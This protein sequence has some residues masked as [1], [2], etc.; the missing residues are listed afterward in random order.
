M[1]KWESDESAF[2][3]LEGKLGPGL[4]ALFH[5]IG[6]MPVDLSRGSHGGLGFM[7]HGVYPP[8]AVE[9]PRFGCFG[10]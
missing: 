8:I 5:A 9:E 4:D 7:E 1:G 2:N 6:S 10:A 3:P